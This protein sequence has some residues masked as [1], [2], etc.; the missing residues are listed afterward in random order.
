[1][2]TTT[3]VMLCVMAALQAQAFCG[4]YVAKADVS[5]FNNAS[6]VIMVRNGE[7]STITMSSDYEG[8]LKEF[9]L[10]IPV[11]VVLQESDIRVANPLIFQKLDAYSTPRM[12]E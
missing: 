1:M 8:D 3:A 9:A 2:K 7:Q 5:L 12:A 10:V 6:Q 4:F 11:P